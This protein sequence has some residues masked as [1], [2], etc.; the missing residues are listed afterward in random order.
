L[1]ISFCMRESRLETDF[2]FHAIMNVN[3][4][5]A[6]FVIIFLCYLLMMAIL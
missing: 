6:C 5:R 1:Q 3:I 4:E 2:E